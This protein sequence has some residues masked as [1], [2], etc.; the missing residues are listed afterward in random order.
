M[1]RGDWI[2]AGLAVIGAG[3]GYGL[4]GS[5]GMADRPLSVRDAELA[6]RDPG[7]MTADEAV[8]RLE[9]LVQS[10]PTDPQPHFFLGELLAGQGRLDDAVRHYQSALRR[11]GEFVPAMIGLADSY[12]QLSEGRVGEDARAIY[13]RAWRLEPGQLRAGFMIGLA[14]WQGGNRA[15]ARQTWKQVG[16]GLAP[17][18]QQAAMFAAWVSAAESSE[19][20]AE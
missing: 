9:S 12:V 10:R 6:A 11:D 19:P 8:A 3:T 13:A 1:K 20:V 2:L 14:D 17:D 18:S 5:P 15:R 7:E 16:E 4:V